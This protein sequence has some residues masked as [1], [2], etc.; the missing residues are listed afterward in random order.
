MK[1]KGRTNL[2][3][4]NCRGC[5]VVH[6]AAGNVRLDLDRGEFEAFAESV[7][8]IYCGQLAGDSYPIGRSSGAGMEI[9]RGVLASSEIH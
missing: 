4:W 6:I 9:V 7:A 5:G 1:D 2:Q 3:I 8:G